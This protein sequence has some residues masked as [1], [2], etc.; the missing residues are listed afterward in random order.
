MFS[1]QLKATVYL[2]K[3]KSL[4]AFTRDALLNVM[5][6]LCM[7]IR[8]ENKSKQKCKHSVSFATALVESDL[9]QERIIISCLNT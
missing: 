7:A 5:H 6:Q 2:L 9:N 1:R 4:K 8:V 3:T